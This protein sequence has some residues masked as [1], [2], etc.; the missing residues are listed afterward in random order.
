MDVR[1][2][3]SSAKIGGSSSSKGAVTKRAPQLL[4][5]AAVQPEAALHPILAWGRQSDQCAE[6]IE[7][8]EFCGGGTLLGAQLGPAGGLFEIGISENY[9]SLGGLLSLSAGP[10]QHN[11]HRTWGSTTGIVLWVQWGLATWGLA[12]WGLATCAHVASPLPQHGVCK[13]AL[14]EGASKAS[15]FSL[16]ESNMQMS[17]GGRPASCVKAYKLGMHAERILPGSHPPARCLA[18]L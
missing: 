7:V 4:P 2:L 9:H 12:T 11:R 15:V 14:P 10:R 13:L 1:R 3:S 16:F 18:P 6:S 5:P 8:D 17:G